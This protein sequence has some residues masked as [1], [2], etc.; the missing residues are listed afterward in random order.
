[1][2]VDEVGGV[3]GEISSVETDLF[4]CPQC[5]NPRRALDPSDPIHARISCIV[6]L[7]V[8][9]SPDDSQPRA[10]LSRNDGGRSKVAP[11]PGWIA[12]CRW[13]LCLDK[14]NLT[15]VVVRN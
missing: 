7:T 1:M 6:F 4:V 14:F 15:R 9:I 2:Y 10:H 11:A 3:S 13:R 5:M 8:Y 12:C